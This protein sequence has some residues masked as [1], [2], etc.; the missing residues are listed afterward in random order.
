MGLSGPLISCIGNVI[1]PTDF[2]IFQGGR[3]TT[4]QNLLNLVFWA[5]NRKI[6][7]CEEKDAPSTWPLYL[8]LS[9]IGMM[10]IVGTTTLRLN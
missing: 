4:N 2:H 10:K 5:I 7:G 6:L 3:S 8:E 1:I 9:G